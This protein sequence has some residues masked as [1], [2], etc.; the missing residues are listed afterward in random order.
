MTMNSKNVVVRAF[1]LVWELEDGTL[2]W[3]DI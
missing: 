1:T 2:L 3:V